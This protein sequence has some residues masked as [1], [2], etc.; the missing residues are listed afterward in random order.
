MTKKKAPEDK[1]KTGRPTIYNHELA[2]EI[3]NVIATTSLGLKKLCASREDFPAP[4]TVRMWTFTHPEFSALYEQA[5][6][7]QSDIIAEECRDIAEDDS[8]DSIYDDNGELVFNPT[9]VPRS[10]LRIY[11]NQWHAAKVRPKK[12]GAHRELEEKIEENEKLKEELREL[13]EKL[14]V[15]YKKEY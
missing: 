3:C 13:R 10:R 11:T 7:H 9:S 15:Q 2:I 12:Y 8:K 4:D 1:V 6:F 14:D 5:K